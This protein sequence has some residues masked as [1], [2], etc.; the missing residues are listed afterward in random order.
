M[1]TKVEEIV[2]VLEKF[3]DYGIV[4][5]EYRDSAEMIEKITEELNTLANGVE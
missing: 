1:L 3:N 5:S 4:D 2:K